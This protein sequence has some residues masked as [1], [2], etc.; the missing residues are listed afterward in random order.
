MAEGF[1][2][3]SQLTIQ[4]P[5]CPLPNHPVTCYCR[6]TKRLTSSKWLTRPKAPFPFL[7]PSFHGPLPLALVWPTGLV[8]KETKMLPSQGFALAAPPA[9]LFLPCCYL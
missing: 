8:S 1:H 9:K 5:E 7:P 4:Q 6:R 2:L 3:K